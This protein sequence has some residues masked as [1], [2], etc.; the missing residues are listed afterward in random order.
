MI[1][2]AWTETLKEIIPLPLYGPR[3]FVCDGFPSGCHIM[4]VGTNPAT[5]LDTNWWSFWI[6]K[7]RFDYNLFRRK[8]K[9]ARGDKPPSKTRQRLRLIHEFVE[10]TGKRWIDTNVYRHEAESEKAV[11]KKNWCPNGDVLDV[12]VTKMDKLEAIVVYQRYAYAWLREQ[13][14]PPNIL[15]IFLTGD[16]PKPIWLGSEAALLRTCEQHLK[17]VLT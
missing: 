1:N 5:P 12:L 13:K 14:L 15:R 11:K 8:Y 17:G 6:D 4:I 7:S 9:D 2:T 16:Q 10:Q 3:P